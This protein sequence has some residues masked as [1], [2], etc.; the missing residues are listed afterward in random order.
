M[1]SAEVVANDGSRSEAQPAGARWSERLKALRRIPP[2]FRMVWDCAPE[3][4]V[5]GSI[6]RVVV[7]VIPVALLWVTR[8]II[9]A[10]NS[11]LAYHAALR[12]HFWWLVALEFVLASVVAMMGRV[13]TFFDTV[14]ADKF[15]RHISTRI[16]EHAS[17]LDLTRYEDPL[18]TTRWSARA[19]KA[20]T[21]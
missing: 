6:A 17:R 13:L 14:L 20:P 12:P 19:C 4:V 15:T 16:M 10:I 21:A 9:D 1:P 5:L 8:I 7:S 2:I 3:V 18:S 11:H